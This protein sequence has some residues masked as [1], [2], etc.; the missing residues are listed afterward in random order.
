MTAPENACQVFNERAKIVT[1]TKENK[2]KINTKNK[3]KG[4]GERARLIYLKC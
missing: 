4:N 3:K 2:I 1:I